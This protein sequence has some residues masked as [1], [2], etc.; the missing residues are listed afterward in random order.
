MVTTNNQ[1]YADRVARFVSLGYGLVSAGAGKS[2]IDKRAILH[3]S[4]KRHVSLGYNYRMSELCAAVAFAQLERLD[5]FVAWR[6]RTANAF[7]EVV[8]SC[9]WLKPQKVGPEYEHSYW[10]Y[11]LKLDVDKND[12]TWQEFYDKFVEL[13]GDGFYGAWSLTYLEPVFQDGSLGI[14]YEA[15]ICP[16][17]EAIQPRLMQ[18]KTN[19]GDQN[20]IDCQAEA[21]SKYYQLF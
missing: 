11:V 17:A 9:S 15:G 4:F 2:K 12:L 20:T 16:V 3:P 21:P 6:K 5:E 14:K 19:Y 1:E 13:G 10:A 18:F 8:R 7:D